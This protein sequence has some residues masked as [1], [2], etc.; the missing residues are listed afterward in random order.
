VQKTFDSHSH[1][2]SPGSRSADVNR[3]QYRP[4][5]GR[6]DD[7][8]WLHAEHSS[9]S[10]WLEG[11]RRPRCPADE[12]LADGDTTGPL[13]LVSRQLFRQAGRA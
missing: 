5:C 3:T 12:W 8:V 7:D 2:A 6:R 13:A 10:C 11:Q 4:R 1:Y 9:N